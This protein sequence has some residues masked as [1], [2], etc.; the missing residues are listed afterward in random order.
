MAPVRWVLAYVD[1]L[2]SDFSVYH[3]IRDVTVLP[4][5]SFLKLAARMSAY[6]GVVARTAAQ[7]RHGS[8]V[9][10]PQ[11]TGPE[12]APAP[13]GVAS[14]AELQRALAKVPGSDMWGEVR[15]VKVPPQGGAESS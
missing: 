7:A 11:G 3:G 4:S 6:G 9:K 12:K 15:Q 2:A 10:R 8:G 13:V 14:A 5:R 1:D